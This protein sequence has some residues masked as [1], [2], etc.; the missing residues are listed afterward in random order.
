[1]IWIMGQSGPSSSLLMTPNC[2]EWIV[3]QRVVLPS[4]GTLTGCRNGLAEILF[5]PNKEKCKV[6]H[7]GRNSPI[8]KYMLGAT[9]L[10]NC[11]AEKALVV[12]VGTKLNMDQ[13]CALA[14]EKASGIWDC[15]RHR[16]EKA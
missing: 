9:Q 15:I 1:M 13:H 2:E 4:R 7:L 3:F 5:N 11:F 14:T 8:D 12:L 6:L 10:K 16:E